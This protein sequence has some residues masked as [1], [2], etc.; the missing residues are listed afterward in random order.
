[1]IFT[2]QHISSN[3][4]LVC[5]LFDKRYTTLAFVS[6]QLIILTSILYEFI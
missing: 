2:I 1:M 4:I 6:Y 5:T 3:Y